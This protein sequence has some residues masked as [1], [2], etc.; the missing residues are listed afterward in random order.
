[1]FLMGRGMKYIFFGLIG[2]LIIGFFYALWVSRDLPTPGKLTNPDLKDSTRILD[3]NGDLLFSFY[4]D[5]NRI[6]VNLDDIPQELRE[7]T[8]AVEDKDFYT[9]KGFSLT[10][11][12]G[13]L[14]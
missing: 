2:F 13:V 4:K 14:L 10:G 7:A 9:N 8:I 6:Y 1:M 3:K 12:V 11:Y 5:I